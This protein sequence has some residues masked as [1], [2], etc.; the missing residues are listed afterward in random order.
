MRRVAKGTITRVQSRY[1]AQEL[2]V[3]VSRSEA[4]MSVSAFTGLLRQVT[5]EI[6]G[7]NMV[8]KVRLVKSARTNNYEGKK[9]Q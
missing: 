7:T 3:E 5:L 4:N 8:K 9:I 1:Y 2:S 6:A